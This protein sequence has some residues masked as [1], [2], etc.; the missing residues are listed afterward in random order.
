MGN[1]S[2]KTLKYL[3]WNAMHIHHVSKLKFKIV[4]RINLKR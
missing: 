1:F 3:V 2:N 4:F